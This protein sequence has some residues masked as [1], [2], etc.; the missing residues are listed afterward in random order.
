MRGSDT[1]REGAAP[2]S[3]TQGKYIMST[4]KT[5]GLFSSLALLGAI[6]AS[7]AHAEY[8]CYPYANG[9]PGGYNNITHQC[10]PLYIQWHGDPNR[11]RVSHEYRSGKIWIGHQNAKLQVK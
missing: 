8:M 2:Q 10:N 9:A 1:I 6:A 5:A 11:L 3:S 7:P 4:L